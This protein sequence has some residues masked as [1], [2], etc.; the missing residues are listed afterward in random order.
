MSKFI[1]DQFEPLMKKIFFLTL[2]LNVVTCVLYAQPPCNPSGDFSFSYNLCSSYEVFFS[3]NATGFTQIRWDFGDGNTN[4]GTTNTVNTYSTQGNYLVTMITDFPSCSDTVRKTITI[5][6][7]NDNQLISTND[8][9]ICLG[10][11]KQILANPGS[12]FCWT[13]TTFLNNP[14]SP[15]PIATPAQTITYHLTSLSTGTNLI[16]NGNFSLGNTGFTSQYLYTNNNTAAAE[17]FIGTDPS[18]WYFAHSPCTDHTSGIGNM[19]MVNG[20]AIPNL[21][22]WKTIVPVTTNTNYAFSVWICSISNPNPA[23]L[24]FSINGNDIGGLIT[25]SI[26]TCNW[27]QFYTTWNSG[28]ATSATISI[29]NKN[30]I[31]FGNDFAL[32]DIS[33]APFTV[34]KDSVT[35][36][37]NCLNACPQKN[38][39]SFSQDPCTPLNATFSTNATGYTNIKWDF[40]DG[41]TTSGI[42]TATNT[43]T[44]PG[45]YL[46]TM[47]TDYTTCSDTVKK[48]ITID[49]QNDNQLVTTT[50]TTICFGTTKQLLSNPGLNFCWIPTTYLNNPN[51]PNPITSTPQ[52]IT[53][54]L[55]SLSSGTNLI[56]NGD[57]SAGNTGF[58]SQYSYTPN[59][60]TEGEY[61]VGTNPQAWNPLAPACPDHTS[62]NG[63]M[64]LVNGSPIPNAEV[65]KT[66]VTVTPN[67]NYIFSTWICPVSNP[68]PAQLAFSINGNSI[69]SLITAALP[70]CNWIQFYTTW[71]SGN[72]TTAT[73][74]I[75]NKNIIAF[76]NDFA[77]DDI[78]FAP[79][80]VKRDSVRINVDN[81]IVNT[82]SDAIICEGTP[83]QLTTSGAA[84]YLWS[85]ATGLSNPSIANPIATPLTTTQYIVTGTTANNCT[86]KDTV[87]ITVNP[88]P[89]VTITDDTTI[90]QNASVQLLATGG[91]SYVWTPTGSLSNPAIANP[92][93][94]PATSTKYFVTVT[95]AVNCNAVDSVTVDVRATNNFTVN[96]PVDICLLESVQL[97]AAGGDLYSWSPALALNN[98][99]IANPLASPQNTTP[100]TV[101]ITD[102]VCNNIATLSTTVTVL[103][104]PMITASSSNDIDC[105]NNQSQLMATG[106]VQYSWSPAASLSNAS[107]VNPVATPLTTTE[108]IVTGED[109]NGCTNK[110]SVLVNV[111]STNAGG[112]LMP[113]AFTPNGD[114]INDCYGIKFW[115][116]ILELDFSI[117]SRWGERV[118]HSKNPSDCWNGTYKGNRQ[119]AAVFVYMIKAKTTCGDV[120][121]K[122][123][124]TLIR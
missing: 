120:F 52:S 29:L 27:N 14:N 45:N 70:T 88:K 102:T 44:N 112:Y 51:S 89:V 61:F 115:G 78:S 16:T 104:L 50:D 99:A 25:A 87:L 107:I 106:G 23:Q 72:A 36:T 77:L 80:T 65:W 62:G 28:T 35:I 85:P 33:F 63:N 48:T 117:Y 119:D 124:F 19:M 57:F 15:S 84:A 90:C 82:N 79:F 26:P 97:N 71:N 31:A 6:L 53:Y 121:R 93:A 54:Y 73:I 41:N 11:S 103:P 81:P 34:K 4:A 100:Y 83:V 12:N 92:V 49:I 20:S 76:G 46:V 59:N 10:S 42:T 118:F 95:N 75:I 116:T 30:I 60:T 69:G 17:Y 24:A 32:D 123:T 37:V 58:T 22:V 91:T 101:T 9:A 105:S 86:A 114:G 18:A 68:N 98:P 3:T 74:S 55:T 2:L 110:D 1:P 5:D 21:E 47:I 40:G 111:T 38:D 113:T 94:T 67:T 8:T 13:P 64:M 108:Y 39:F 122:G 109:I 96:S 43:Y 56:P 7:Q 66:S